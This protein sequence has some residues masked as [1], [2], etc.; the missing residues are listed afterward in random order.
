MMS[1]NFIWNGAVSIKGYSL[2]QSY[3]EMEYTANKPRANP[4]EKR[5]EIVYRP[6]NSAL[7]SAYM[8]SFD[9]AALLYVLNA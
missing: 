6:L 8:Q 1:E 5:R 7:T 3:P 9:M 4:K 2:K